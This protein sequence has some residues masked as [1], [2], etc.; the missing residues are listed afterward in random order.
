[1]NGVPTDPHT[2]GPDWGNQRFSVVSGPPGGVGSEHL[3]SVPVTWRNQ[4][5]GLSSHLGTLLN[6]NQIG[7]TM[8]DEL[9]FVTRSTLV[10]KDPG[11]YGIESVLIK[12]HVF[13]ASNPIL[14]G[15]LLYDAESGQNY[16]VTDD[17]L[18]RYEQSPPE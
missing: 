4:P 1:M 13:N 8:M 3:Y 11:M 9:T 6:D 17:D 16:F 18:A 14:R 2:D 10:M 7:V 5:C 12:K 15:A